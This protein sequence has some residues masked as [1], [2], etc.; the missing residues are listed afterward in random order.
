[1]KAPATQLT[2]R[3]VVLPR[4]YPPLQQSQSR[5][6]GVGPSG[7][8]LWE[9]PLVL[10]LDISHYKVNETSFLNHALNVLLEGELLKSNTVV[11][12]S[13]DTPG[14]LRTVVKCGLY[15]EGASAL[16]HCAIRIDSTEGHRVNGLHM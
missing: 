8:N 1:V 7:R 9:R 4:Y 5:G 13:E 11:A 12:Y 14:H 2:E 10:L 16:A 15:I 6:F 3:G